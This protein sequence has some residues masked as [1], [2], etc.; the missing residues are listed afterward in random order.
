MPARRLPK[1]LAPWREVLDSAE[2]ESWFPLIFDRSV[3]A[4]AEAMDELMNDGEVMYIHD[5][6]EAQLKDLVRSRTPS[7]NYTD[8]EV[9]Q[10]IERTLAGQTPQDYG[11]WAFYPWSRRMVHLLPPDPFIELR[12]DRNRNKITSEEQ[13]R[14]RKIKIALA[15][16]SVG[17]AVAVTLALEGVFGELR[18][19][20]FDTLDLSNMN[21]IRCAVHHLGLNK[22]IIAARQ[23]YEQNPYANLVLF[24]DGVTPENI[25]EFIDGTGPGDRADI[26]IDE[27]DSIQ[28]KLKLREEARARRLPV[29]M[30]TSDRGMLDIERFDLEPERPILHG[31]VG[32]VTSD[33]VNTLPP[34]ARL[35]LILQI[36]GLHTISPRLAASLLE[37]NLTLKGFSQLGS[38]VTLGGATTTTAVRRLALGMPL[39]SGRVYIDVSGQLAEVTSP[40]L[41]DLSHPRRLRDITEV[42]EL[43][44]Y[45]IMAPSHG[46]DQPW[47]FE[48]GDSVL[49]VFHDTERAA[50]REEIG[51]HWALVAIGGALANLQIAAG[52]KG[53][54]A[55]IQLFPGKQDPSL[56]AEVRFALRA[57]GPADD[58]LFEEIPRRNTNR[59]LGTRAHLSPVHVQAL[60]AAAR[61]SG[62]KLQLCTDR[63]LLGELGQLLGEA[64]RLRLL[65]PTLHGPTMRQIRWSEAEAHDTQ[66]GIRVEAL[67]VT[68]MDFAAFQLLRSTDVAKVLRDT[69]GGRL[70]MMSSVQALASSAA[71]GL[72]TIPGQS[73]TALVRGGQAMQQLWLTASALG[74]AIHPINTLIDMFA[75]V[76]RFHGAGFDKREIQRFLEM[77]ERFTRAFTV[78]LADVEIL[79]FRLSYADPAPLRTLRRPVDDVFS[80]PLPDKKSP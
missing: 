51:R 73:P 43:V 61:D 77:R 6:L 60:S 50:G 14:L 59:A 45:A 11:R 65:T 63:G 67:A 1:T 33:Q 25:G 52:V 19:A 71:V 17:N 21:R 24:T 4:E 44:Q 8:D 32:N 42:R 20:D 46:N 40:P 69:N 49:R 68:P 64:E 15:G 79:L 23:I 30:E 37:L 75:R 31:L 12:S 16:L 26:V 56:V 7:K 5:M 13:I 39:A 2:R 57:G 72:L 34:P 55:T 22:A 10:E 78:A 29:L 54:E 41:P 47:R 27:C 58:P 80:A 3:P 36:A 38:D 62:A 35:G 9:A 53:R 76:E 66:D 74:V 18:L 48:Y 28:I 70:L